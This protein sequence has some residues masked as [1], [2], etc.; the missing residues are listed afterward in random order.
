MTTAMMLVL[1][2]ACAAQA[3][4]PGTVQ[5]PTNGAPHTGGAATSQATASA[6]TGKSADE[7]AKPASGVLI[8]QVIAVVNDDLILESDVDLERRFGAFQ[9]FT[10]PNGGFSRDVAIERLI[11]RALILQQA[12]LQPEEAVT[13][14]QVKVE[15]DQLRKDIPACKQYHCETDAGW[16]KFVEDQGF[17]VDELT[18][19]W[20]ERMQIL[21]FIE[22]RFRM[23]IRIDPASIKEYYEKTLLPEY[24]KQNAK[25][26]PL[27]AISDRIQEV[28]LQQQVS[29]LLDD[30]LE[31]L[32][33]QGAVRM[34]KPGEVK[35]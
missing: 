15:L 27:D 29:K 14:D 5:A 1:A 11:D 4:V 24:A 35:P 12:K 30:W 10:S 18:Q 25:A 17:T 28:L 20:Q 31:S 13:P 8:D 26:P 19:R 34:M 2:L 33:A 22:Q 6:P 16:A 23:G 3:P 21:K 32:K 7:T 9:P